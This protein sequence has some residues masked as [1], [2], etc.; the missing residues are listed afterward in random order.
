MAVVLFATSKCQLMTFISM[1][2]GN[3]ICYMLLAQVYGDALDPSCWSLNPLKAP[4]ISHSNYIPL[5][6]WDVGI[7]K[8]GQIN[9]QNRE[10]FIFKVQSNY[11]IILLIKVNYVVSGDFYPEINPKIDIF[12]K[13]GMRKT[14]VL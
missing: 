7:N 6:K 9:G 3:R 2:H 5:S 1:Q 12:I 11:L 10:A 14:N 13:D 4:D 8:E